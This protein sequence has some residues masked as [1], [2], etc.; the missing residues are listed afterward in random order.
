VKKS[1]ALFSGKQQ[2]KNTNRKDRLHCREGDCSN[3]AQTASDFGRSSGVGSP[4]VGIAMP[5]GR[6]HKKSWSH[7]LAP[8]SVRQLQIGIQLQTYKESQPS[9]KTKT[10][11]EEKNYIIKYNYSPAD[12]SC[13][14][15]FKIFQNFFLQ[16]QLFL[17]AFGLSRFQ[18]TI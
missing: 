5:R 3:C 6:T 12:S 16:I 9:H 8:A 2:Q 13:K 10:V 4:S 18:S 17:G 14:Y 11:Q 15:F 7:L 1:C